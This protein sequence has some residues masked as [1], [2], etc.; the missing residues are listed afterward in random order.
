MSQKVHVMELHHYRHTNNFVKKFGVREEFPPLQPVR[1]TPT[2][3]PDVMTLAGSLEVFAQHTTAHG[4][5]SVYHLR[6]SRWAAGL[7]LGITAFCL[8]GV[9]MSVTWATSIVSEENTQTTMRV[10]RHVEG[11]MMPDLVFCNSHI[12]NTQA[13]Q[14]AGLDKELRSYVVALAGGVNQ[15]TTEFKNNSTWRLQV[16]RRFYTL[17]QDYGGDVLAHLRQVSWRCEDFVVKCFS[18]N[19]DLSGV[20]CCSRNFQ[21]LVS[22]LGLCYVGS[23]NSSYN[24]RIE[25]EAMGMSFILRVPQE[26]PQDELDWNILKKKNFIYSGLQAMV[27]KKGFPATS[28]EKYPINSGQKVNLALYYSKINNELWT[29][30]LWPWSKPQCTPRDAPTEQ[31]LN[32]RDNC[33]L[34][35]IYNTFKKM[36]CSPLVSPSFLTESYPACNITSMVNVPN[37][38]ALYDETKCNVLCEE[39]KF[40][41]KMLATHLPRIYTTLDQEL[42]QPNSSLRYDLASLSMYYPSLSYTEIILTKPGLGD[43]I[44]SLGGKVGLCI[45]ASI[46]TTLELLGFSLWLVYL[47]LRNTVRALC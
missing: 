31:L 41:V 47:C 29:T 15:V 19:E 11:A 5:G 8:V 43:W 1:F 35:G 16:E 25:G 9:I 39:E 13:A 3:Q 6:K 21:P 45:G 17:L 10:G 2:P 33:F 32:T 22:S 26:P 24:Q 12:F 44:S 37:Q 28:S 30:S 7:S 18:V 27:R 14:D 36:N 46:I 4:F 34:G 23:F 20:E 42:S 38:Y 40:E